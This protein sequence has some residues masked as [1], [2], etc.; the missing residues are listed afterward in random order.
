MKI[1]FIAPYEEL[2]DLVKE[3]SREMN[4]EVDVF[5]GSFEDAG[6][7]A[8]KLEANGY[9]I[10]ISRGATYQHIKN[11][12]KIPIINCH[13]TSFDIL[14]ALFDAVQYLK[15]ERKV[16]LILPK[17]L[18]L[19]GKK[20]SE[21]FNIELIY[22]ASYKD[23]AETKV[24][25]KEAI[26][27][28]AEVII[29]GIST[30]AY[31]KA[32]GKKAILLKTSMET[33]RQS[34]NNAIQIFNLSKKK[35]MEAERLNN[36]LSF[37][38]EGIMVVDENGIVN[39]FNPVAERIFNIESKNIIGKRA[40]KFI[41]TTKLI[42]VVQTGQAQLSQ[43][44]KVN[45]NTILTNRIPIKVKEKVEG[46]VA[47]FQEISKIQDYEKMIRSKLYK[48]G[49]TA[50]YTFYEYIGENKE[51]KELIEK[52]KIYAKTDS[53]VLIIGE[54][55]TGKEI[56]A[57]SIHNASNRNNNPFV[58]VNCSAI[59]ENLLESELFGY[60][61]GAF[62]GA[63]KGGQIGL[64]ELAHTGTILLDEIGSMPLKL[65][66][67]LLRVLQEKE[68][69]RL[70]SDR[71]IKIDVRVIASTNVNL[72]E[73]AN[74]GEFRSDLY[75][76]L[77][78]LKLETLPLRKRK[79]DI[80]LLLN[81]FIKK[82]SKSSISI[83]EKL[84]NKIKDYDWP[85]NVRELQNFVERISYLNGYISI[86]KIFQELIESNKTYENDIINNDSIVVKKGT[87]QEMEDQ[88]LKKLYD[89]YDHNSTLLAEK[90]DISRT[91]LWKKL[92][93][94]EQKVNNSSIKCLEHEHQ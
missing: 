50:N 28:G 80:E 41:P 59:P 91:T 58:A 5:T 69:W 36:I 85:G 1:G 26:E 21:I 66:S 79:D 61:E 51:V 93:I 15:N 37:S 60:E 55:G 30:V 43:I 44:Q 14:Y 81:Y 62:S 3:I 45:N 67:R 83:S 2:T 38:Y 6:T 89:E 29:G 94:I 48:K 72:F 19:E 64:F 33:V 87:K 73:A 40:D 13:M 9:D 49:L 20:V 63:K 18:A 27:K 32:L 39:F 24:M 23:I 68:V 86:D 52:A 12:I 53:T 77:N 47:T 7:M 17:D 92:K 74:K 54:S 82:Y 84:I 8:K 34:I 90:L 65:Q 42:E 70:G 71:S 31:A 57:Q 75:F 78:I 4:V 76:R 16:G 22:K 88:I 11:S 46:A 10:L 25:V 35:M 56:L